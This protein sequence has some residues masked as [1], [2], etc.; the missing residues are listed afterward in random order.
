MEQT[1][2][3]VVVVDVHPDA[4]CRQQQL[5]GGLVADGGGSHQCGAAAAI[6]DVD[7]P[8]PYH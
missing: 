2:A 6:G 3:A 7:L 8:A 5:D 1:C 4:A